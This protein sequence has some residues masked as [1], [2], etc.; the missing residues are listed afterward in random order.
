MLNLEKEIISDLATTILGKPC[1]RRSCKT[2]GIGRP[3]S[4]G[5]EIVKN[6]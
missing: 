2:R 5:Q 3:K 1:K 4:H 6:K